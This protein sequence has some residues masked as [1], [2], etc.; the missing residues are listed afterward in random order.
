VRLNW[1]RSG[2]EPSNN[3]SGATPINQV[4][5]LDPA[6][7]AWP[8]NPDSAQIAGT[9]RLDRPLSILLVDVTGLDWRQ[10]ELLLPT[11]H[12][13]AH[14]KGLTP[15]LVVDLADYSEVR[16]SGLAYDVL[17]NVAANVSF[18]PALDW[19]TYLA[20]RR[21]ILQ[22]KWNPTAIIKLGPGQPWGLR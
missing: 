20:A 21:R 2:R 11:A 4:A 13:V 12:S 10:I 3:G 15:V 17:P 9:I 5:Q 1:I 22:R 18:A 19:D 16:N 7:A 6:E 14:D 8:F